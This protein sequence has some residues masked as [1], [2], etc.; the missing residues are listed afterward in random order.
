VL[1][2]PEEDGHSRVIASLV[3]TAGSVH[4]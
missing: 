1:W 4:A 3:E 2:H